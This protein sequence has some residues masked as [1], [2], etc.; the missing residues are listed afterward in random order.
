[1]GRHEAYFLGW[2]LWEY[3]SVAIHGD[4]TGFLLPKSASLEY[5]HD[6]TISLRP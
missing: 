2:G 6:R 1:M 4:M 3:H 5:H